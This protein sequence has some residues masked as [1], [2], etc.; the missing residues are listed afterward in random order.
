MSNWFI[1]ETV[2]GR[3]S[4]VVLTLAR[5]GFTAWRPFYELR[6]ADR[7]STAS[8]KTVAK[9]AHPP[10]RVPRFGRYFFLRCDLSPSIV[11]EVRHMAGV[12]DWLRSAGSY[13]PIPVPERVMAYLRGEISPKP[14]ND[15]QDAIRVGQRVTI[16]LEFPLWGGRSGIVRA[17]DRRG[18]LRVDIDQFGSPIPFVIEV[19]HIVEGLALAKPPASTVS[20]SARPVIELAA[21]A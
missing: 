9:A 13:D 16:A 20:Q 5:A 17:I 10:R 7:R 1:V 18:Q 12:R 3:T 21:G 6:S 4:D 8:R 19:G 2:E 14:A 15:W 11:H